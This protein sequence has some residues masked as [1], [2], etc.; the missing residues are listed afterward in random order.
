MYISK[1]NLKNIRGFT[2]LQFDLT[3]EDGTYAG[4]TVFTL[5]LIH[6]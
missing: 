1:V 5:S 2:D 4:W 3:R 6:I